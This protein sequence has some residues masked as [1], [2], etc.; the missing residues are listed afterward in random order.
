MYDLER[1]IRPVGARYKEIIR[2]WRGV[3]AGDERTSAYDLIAQGAS[4]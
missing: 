1:K 4:A 2:Q 3:L